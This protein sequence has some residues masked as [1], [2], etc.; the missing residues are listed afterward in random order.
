VGGESEGTDRL[1]IITDRAIGDALRA[2]RRPLHVKDPSVVCV[3]FFKEYLNT[4]FRF[5]LFHYVFSLIT[6]VSFLKGS[7]L[8]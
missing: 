7:K 4:P 3:T 5:N 8:G 1:L 2:R 6:G